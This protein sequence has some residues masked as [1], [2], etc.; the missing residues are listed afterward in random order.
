[1]KNFVEWLVARRYRMVLAAAAFALLPALGIL[2]QAVVILAVLIHGLREGILVAAI[3]TALMTLPALFAGTNATAMLLFALVNWVPAVALAAVLER[4]RS[5]SLTAQVATIAVAAVVAL[6]FVFGAPVE[7]WRIV[8]DEYIAAMAE[9]IGEVP[10]GLVT[11]LSRI[12]T[13]TIGAFALLSSMAAVF[14]GRWWQSILT[15][16]GAFSSEFRDLRMGLI[17]G[18]VAGVVFVA[19]ALTRVTLL[20]NLTLVLVS[21]FL[22]HGLA[23]LHS[24]A[25]AGTG[26]FW[27][28][29]VYV[30]LVVAIPFA[31]LAV[32]GL[33][34]IDN[35]F[36]LRSR[37]QRR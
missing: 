11:E 7:S 37:V 4:S 35:W 3:A 12:M 19:A 32:A 9:R 24:I 5:L 27:L 22:V 23:V 18:L 21:G 6:F 36:D 8:L 26:S 30:L 13:G 33:G 16:P 14:I 29:A 28:V 10:D 15:R 2:G 31:E 1:M 25:A 17:V 20:E 34:F